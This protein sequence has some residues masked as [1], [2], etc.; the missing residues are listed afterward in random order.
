MTRMSKYSVEFATSAYNEGNSLIE[1]LREIREAMNKYLPGVSYRVVYSDNNSEDNTMEVLMNGN[2]PCDVYYIKNCR[3]YGPERSMINALSCCTADIVAILASDLQDPPDDAVKAVR[4]LI[5]D[6]TLDACCG[7]KVAT[8][9]FRNILSSSYYS[10]CRTFYSKGVIKNFHSF[11]AYRKEII[12]YAVTESISTGKFLRFSLVEKLEGVAV[13]DYV[14]RERY[15]GTSS[16]RGYNRLIKEGLNS[17]RAMDELN[18]PFSKLITLALLVSIAFSSMSLENKALSVQLIGLIFVVNREG[19]R[20][21]H[22]M[23]NLRFKKI[24]LAKA[25]QKCPR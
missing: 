10:I 6:N 17:I 16:Y 18:A 1:L 21:R 22:V 13:F 11:G 19:G 9:N 14:Q 2:L 20:R 5:M 24:E 7:I 25:I 15:H 23:S 3:N 4:R 8:R 12:R